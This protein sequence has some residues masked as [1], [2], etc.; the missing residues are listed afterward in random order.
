VAKNFDGHPKL[1][2]L[3]YTFW[4]D[5]F[6]DYFGASDNAELKVKVL[7]ELGYKVVVTLHTIKEVVVY[8]N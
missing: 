5:N 6:S 8:E 1:T 3:E 4:V 2:P 7:V